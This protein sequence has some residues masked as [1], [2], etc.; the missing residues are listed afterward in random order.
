MFIEDGDESMALMHAEMIRDLST[1]EWK[2]TI[3]ESSDV[4]PHC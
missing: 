1:R 4:Y 3:G 2:K